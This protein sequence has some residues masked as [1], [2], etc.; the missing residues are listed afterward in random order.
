MSDS[1]FRTLSAHVDMFTPDERRDR[2]ALG[3]VHGEHG[4]LLVEGGASTA[5]LVAFVAELERRG[6]PPVVGIVLTH[7]HWDHSFGSAAVDTPVI[8][9]RLSAEALTRQAAFDWSDE[10]LDARV[11][12]G[13]ELDFCRDMMKLEMPDRSRLRIVLPSVVVDEHHAVELGGATA[14]IDHVGGDHA[15]DSLAVYVPEDRVIFLGDC[16]YQRLHAPVEHLTVAGVRALTDR[17]ARYDVAIAV[18]GHNDDVADA[19]GFAA[20][21]AALRSA[22]D[23]VERYGDAAVAHAVGDEDVEEAVGFLLAGE[24]SE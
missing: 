10:A 7:W 4:M 12:A 17:L 16:L 3:A 6:R 19:G 24:R 2:P 20:R 23:L 18:E 9:H 21:L 14:V 15:P 5:H 1:E 8:A 11:A 13:T 22:A